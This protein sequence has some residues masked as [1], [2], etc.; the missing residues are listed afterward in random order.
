MR[1]LSLNFLALFILVFVSALDSKAQE[2]RQRIFELGYQLENGEVYD[3][4][5]DLNQ[6]SK[7]YKRQNDI[8]NL[9]TVYLGLCLAHEKLVQL[10]SVEYY[11][12]LVDENIL[13]GDAL[14]LYF[15]VDAQRAKRGVI[16]QSR[17]ALIDSA[18]RYAVSPE[19]KDYFHLGAFDPVLF[20]ATQQDVDSLVQLLEYPEHPVNKATIKHIR[21]YSFWEAYDYDSAVILG[22]QLLAD[23]NASLSLKGMA[24]RWESQ[25][26]TFKSNNMD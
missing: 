17:Y 24:K 3:A 21:L 14:A 25:M 15:Y 23:P 22:K 26:L 6:L 20:G 9:N 10:D 7:K 12:G 13:S 11:H 2:R 1:D 19:L 18:K 16:N 5:A 8:K 4:L